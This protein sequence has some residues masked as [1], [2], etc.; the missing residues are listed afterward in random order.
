MVSH[1]TVQ[2]LL[3]YKNITPIEAIA[4]EGMEQDMLICYSDLV[5]MKILRPN[6]PKVVCNSTQEDPLKGLTVH[7]I[8]IHQEKATNET[9]Q[10]LLK[11]GI[12]RQ[13]YEPTEWISPALFVAKPNGKVRL[14]TDYH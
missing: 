6:F 5:K 13:V 9:I 14:V 10:S 8:P 2:I 7:R 11:A 3:T 12:I 1:G 4:T